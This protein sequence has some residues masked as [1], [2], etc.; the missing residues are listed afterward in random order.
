MNR[1]LCVWFPNFPLQRFLREQP[2]HRARPCILYQAGQRGAQVVA[3]SR[4]AT[5][6]RITPGMSLADAQSLLPAAHFEQHQPDADTAALQSL[7]WHSDCFSPRIGIEYFGGLACLLMDI[8]GGSHLFGGDHSLA[9]QVA[10]FVAKQSFFAHVAIASTIGASWAIACYGHSTG[11]DRRMRSL[12]VEA[13][14]LPDNVIKRLYDLDLRRVCQLLTLPKEDLPSRFTSTL[15]K[16]L[17]QLFGRLHEDFTPTYRPE[18]LWA[19]WSS[20]DC[21]LNLQAVQYVCGDLLDDIL[22]RLQSRCEGVTRLRLELTGESGEPLVIEQETV[23]PYHAGSVSGS[24]SQCLLELLMLQLEGQQLPDG[25]HTIH[26]DALETVRIAVRQQTL[27]EDN[28]IATDAAF[29]QLVDRLSTR[30]GPQTVVQSDIQPE[31]LPED[32]V[33]YWPSTQSTKRLC[34]ETA[35][36]EPP[37][38]SSR[39]TCLLPATLISVTDESPAGLPIHIHW[40]G[41]NYHVV[42]CTEPEQIETNWWTAKGKA[43]RS[44]VRVE[45]STGQRFW[46]YRNERYEWFL[47]GLFD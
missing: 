18:T 44:Y 23:T 32:S 34:V 40:Q 12:P 11:S 41:Q 5:A 29:H 26:I 20:D 38:T 2:E 35:K 8:T 10:V 3:C 16:R 39:P 46:L 28:G 42:Q 24:S 13:L 6:E 30:L 47:H 25:L 19:A 43:V 17:E 36:C 7:A 21:A 45:V 15:P 22:N 33:R 9:G 14:R 31:P 37:P 4:E 27:F 1:V